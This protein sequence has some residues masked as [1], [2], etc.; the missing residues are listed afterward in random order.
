MAPAYRATMMIRPVR[1][2]IKAPAAK[3]MSFFQKLWL[4]RAVGSL[5][6]SS[7]PS[8]AQKPPMGSSR[9]E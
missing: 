9:R 7:S 3:M 5:E 8:M 2:F 6:S 1:K 4:F